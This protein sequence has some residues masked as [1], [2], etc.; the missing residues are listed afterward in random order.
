MSDQTELAPEIQAEIGA[1]QAVLSALSP[2]DEETRRLILGYVQQR[3]G[4]SQVQTPSATP[5]T[6]SLTPVEAVAEQFTDIR[7]LKEKKRPANAVDMAVLVAYYLAE[8]AP[9]SERRET[10]GTDEVTR[11]FQ[12]ADYRSSGQPRVILHRAKNA[13]YLDSAERGQYKLN[14][15]GRNLAI[16]GLPR[17]E[18]V[19]TRSKPAA[20]RRK[21]RA[22][23]KRGAAKKSPT[24]KRKSARSR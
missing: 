22:T 8:I 14:P 11:Y 23:P 16:Q 7:T 3:F 9:D 19:A 24:A 6:A 21:A 2:L 1:L 10:I 12:Q 4:V 20:K 15:V 5:S 13:G 18:S 17:V